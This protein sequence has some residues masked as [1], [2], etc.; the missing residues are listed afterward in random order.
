MRCLLSSIS[1]QKQKKHIVVV[2]EDRE[3]EEEGV[4]GVVETKGKRGERE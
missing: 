2:E 3:A 4:E 1:R